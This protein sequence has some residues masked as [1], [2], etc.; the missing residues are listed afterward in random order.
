MKKRLLALLLSLTLVT[1][2]IPSTTHAK[3]TDENNLIKNGSFEDYE[4]VDGNYIPENWVDKDGIWALDDNYYVANPDENKFGK[5]FYWPKLQ[6]CE[7]S[8]A[9][10]DVDIS[11]YEAGQWFELKA[12]LC[13]YAQSPNDQ[14]T[15][16]LS[17]LDKNNKT[18][19]TYNR[20]Q[21]NPQ[22]IEQ[23]ITAE[24]PKNAVKIRV[25]LIA[26][27]FVGN[28]NDAYFDLIRLVPVTGKVEGVY[29]TGD[30]NVK[31]GKSTTLTA[32]N[33]KSTDAS[34]YDWSSSYDEWATVNKNG[35]VTF[36]DEYDPEIGVT[37]YATEKKTG[38]QGAF[39]FGKNAENEIPVKKVT[40]LKASVRTKTAITL[41]WTKSAGA[42]KYTVY[43]LNPSTK[44]YEKVKTTTAAKL[45][46]S[47]LK[48]GKQYS[49][50]VVAEGK[51]G[52]ET[53]TA[54]ASSILK[55]KT[56]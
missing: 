1:V 41:K 13:N 56:K 18:L 4:E 28:D 29:I 34:L 55:A 36:S 9:Y 43:K 8:T 52:T 42:T 23:T 21:R 25:K 14:A 5:Y 48:S 45:K 15:V 20:S 50:K 3:E 53:Y 10:Q 51:Y 26:T 37:I 22:W 6:A 19:I 46:V 11:E 7:S 39:T 31:A 27:R 17:F 12:Y 2:L 24:K 49:F 40:G 38:F 30:A 54:A 32:N 33:G 35:K 47:K 44:K 16:S